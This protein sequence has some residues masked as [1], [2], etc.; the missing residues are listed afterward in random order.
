MWNIKH[1]KRIHKEEQKVVTRDT[2]KETDGRDTY[3]QTNMEKSHS[4]CKMI[5]TYNKK[6]ERTNSTRNLKIRQ[7]KLPGK[8]NI[9]LQYIVPVTHKKNLSKEQNTREAP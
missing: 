5:R 3:K 4:K 2:R 7:K 9:S 8:Q 1:I 6:R